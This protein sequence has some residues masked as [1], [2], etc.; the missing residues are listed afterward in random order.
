M[1]H[2]ESYT[3][4]D[5][6]R[7]L[8]VSKL[9]V[10]DLIKK[11]E[12]QAYRVGRQMRID[13]EQLALYK[14]RSRE[15]SNQLTEERIAEKTNL[16]T[17][18]PKQVVISGQ[19]RSLDIVARYLEDQNGRYEP[20]RSQRGSLD[21]LMSLYQNE[22][23]IV[24]THLFAGDSHSYNIPY[25]KRLLVSHSFILI[26]LVKRTAGLY[27]QK[28][29]PHHLTSWEHLSKS[30]I[31]MI[32]RERGSGARVLLDEQLRVHDINPQVL[33]GYD[34]VETSHLAVASAVSIGD[35]DVGV[36]IEQVASLA[37]ID[38]IPLIQENYD[39]V[40]IK[41]KANAQLIQDLRKILQSD[42][43]KTELTALGYDTT[44]I[45]RIQFEQ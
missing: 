29:N 33:S 39:L 6:A 42:K 19:D 44:E 24:S 22:R 25:I 14:Q 35:A 37:N 4:D 32:N 26:H 12:L 8:K 31:R 36:G 16:I 1:T 41:N 5:I 3:T 11:G 20:L 27:V 17:E 34:R 2:D 38:F 30:G 7:L 40:L 23:Q 28:G 43:I 13:P 15:G 18:N 45:G 9:T 21:G 10:Y